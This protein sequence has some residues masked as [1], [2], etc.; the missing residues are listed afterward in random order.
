MPRERLSFRQRDLRAALKA[1]KQAGIS[2]ARIEIGKDGIAIIP[3]EPVP[4][5]ADIDTDEAEQQAIEE[6]IRHGKL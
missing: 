4:Q 1:A 2:V 6:A 5:A 3:G